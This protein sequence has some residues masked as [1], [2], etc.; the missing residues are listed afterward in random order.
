MKP[1]LKPPQPASEVPRRAENDTT[2]VQRRRAGERS[3]EGADGA[4]SYLHQDRERPPGP[5]RRGHV[6]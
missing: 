2:E 5:N 3:G 6:S 4:R 1:L